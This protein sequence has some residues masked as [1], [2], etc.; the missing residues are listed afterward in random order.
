MRLPIMISFVLFLSLGS[1]CFAA[2][3]AVS[4][5][6]EKLVSPAA[7]HLRELTRI[8]PEWAGASPGTPVTYS[9]LDNTP[10]AI[11]YPVIKDG[12]EAGYFFLTPD[13]KSVLEFSTS[14]SPY[15][16]A[17]EELK[18]AVRG[19]VGTDRKIGE[20]IFL[21][22]GSGH[23]LYRFPVNYQDKE[24]F[25]VTVDGFTKGVVDGGMGRTDI[26]PEEAPAAEIKEPVFKKLPVPSFAHE[27]SSEATA[28][29]MILDYW[30]QNG[31][32]KLHPRPAPENKQRDESGFIASLVKGCGGCG[33]RTTV[34]IYGAS[35]GYVVKTRYFSL[36]SADRPELSAK[37]SDY[38]NEIDQG[39]PV[40]VKLGTAAITH[41][42][43]GIGYAQ[44]ETGTYLIGRHPRYNPTDKESDFVGYRWPVFA[45]R[46]ELFFIQP[47]PEPAPQQK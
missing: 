29:A 7:G 3:D 20:P 9:R 38:Q 1:C 44:T 33:G 47:Q 16:A 5:A 18:K 42:F 31:F 6:P 4:N 21:Y 28:L 19:C 25:S 22:P 46:I 12:K 41:C 40:L 37:F 8:L 14:L 43:V 17:M 27:V 15:T 39:R 23:F 11:E 13:E 2:G 10:S 35:L 26:R 30:A 45:D 36:P 34:E 24:L 32:E